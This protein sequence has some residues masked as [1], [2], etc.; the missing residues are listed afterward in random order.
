[1]SRNGPGVHLPPPLLYA[2]VYTA[3]LGLDRLWPL[4][5]LEG[6]GVKLMSDLLL[7]TSIGLGVWG[8]RSFARARTTILPFRPSRSLITTGPF[9]FTRNPLYLGL[10][11]AYAGIAL[12]WGMLWPLLLL[13]AAVWIIARY[14]IRAEEA[15]LEAVFGEQYR[16]YRRRVRR[17]LGQRAAS[18]PDR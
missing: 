12:G 8:L 7:V 2:L 5:R 10:A 17:W 9:R 3:G 14:V 13:P 18:P 6:H 1:M 4:P 15:H 11:L 16:A